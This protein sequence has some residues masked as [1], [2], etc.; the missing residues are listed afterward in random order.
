LKK[1]KPQAK[2]R[3]WWESKGIHARF[4]PARA[5][6]FKLLVRPGKEIT[7]NHWLLL[8]VKDFD[9]KANHMR[10]HYMGMGT[11]TKAKGALIAVQAV[12]DCILTAA[13]CDS[14]PP[15][16]EGHRPGQPLWQ[17]AHKQG[18]RVD[19]SPAW[20]WEEGACLSPPPL[21]SSSGLASPKIWCARTKKAG[22]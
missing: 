6:Q 4:Q 7:K 21:R 3:F 13:K 16:H 18:N 15:P 2:P 11:Y 12:V 17:S 10:R 5:T 8:K 19:P 14:P 22:P 9:T 20:S 1:N